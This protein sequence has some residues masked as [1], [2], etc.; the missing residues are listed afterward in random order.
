MSGFTG[1]Y[2]PRNRKRNKLVAGR[3]IRFQ[4]SGF[5]DQGLISRIFRL[6]NP[7][8]WHLKPETQYETSDLQPE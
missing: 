6:V 2:A 4:V 3:L 8:T 5:S 1:I 7:D